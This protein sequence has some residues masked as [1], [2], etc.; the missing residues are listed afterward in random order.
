MGAGYINHFFGNFE[1]SHHCYAS[2]YSWE[3]CLPTE[4]G[5]YLT[6]SLIALPSRKNWEA[7]QSEVSTHSTSAP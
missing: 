7:L 4:L 3:S 6:P 1:M 5:T 2:S